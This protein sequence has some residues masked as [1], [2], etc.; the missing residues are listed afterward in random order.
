MRRTCLTAAGLALSLLLGYHGGA[1]AQEAA[2]GEARKFSEMFA[3]LDV[4]R[5]GAL[6]VQEVDPAQRPAFAKLLEHA[7]AN[8]DGRID[9]GEF[10]AL[11]QRVVAARKTAAAKPG[12]KPTPVAAD[13]SDG[14]AD[15]R[16]QRL[17]TLIDRL[18]AQD[19]DKDGRLSRAEFRGRAAAFERLDA[20]QDGFLD[21]SDLKALRERKAVPK[22]PAPA[23]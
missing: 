1:E 4:D 8:R 13:G 23:E 19:A 9:P 20:N 11:A 18:K 21:R 14:P 17:K 6:E 22:P 5:N 7:D 10:D 15:P 12:E 2:T 3:D 16:I